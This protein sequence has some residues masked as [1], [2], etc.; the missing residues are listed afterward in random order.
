MDGPP[1]VCLAPAGALRLGIVITCVP[2]ARDCDHVSVI[3]T[4]WVW[5]LQAH[6]QQ[7]RTWQPDLGDA[8]ANGASPLA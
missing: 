4:H 7:A 6:T 1:I 2:K 3:W 8:P 5:A